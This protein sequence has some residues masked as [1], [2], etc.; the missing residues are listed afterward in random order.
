[1]MAIES[2]GSISASV[3]SSKSLEKQVE[4]QFAYLLIVVVLS[5]FVV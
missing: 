4:K 2:E 5:V 3:S 1:M